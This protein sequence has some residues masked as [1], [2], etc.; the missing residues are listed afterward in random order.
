MQILQSES[1]RPDINAK[2]KKE[3]IHRHQRKEREDTQ[4]LERKREK[5]MKIREKEREDTQ[6]EKR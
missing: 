4:T 1:E 2:R 3:K 6:N 5:I